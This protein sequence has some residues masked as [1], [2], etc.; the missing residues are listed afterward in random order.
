[1]ITKLAAYDSYIYARLGIDNSER[2]VC[3]INSDQCIYYM[4][5]CVR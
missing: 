5:F 4:F 1:M 3:K 2:I